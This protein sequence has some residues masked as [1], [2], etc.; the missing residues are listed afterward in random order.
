MS[1]A[2]GSKRVSKIAVLII[3]VVVAAGVAIW[4]SSSSNTGRVSAKVEIPANGVQVSVGRGTANVTVDN[5]G[6]APTTI[7]TIYVNGVGYSACSGGEESPE[8]G[9]FYP[10]TCSGA[11]C[12]S[13]N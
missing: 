4:F 13:A 6:S 3:V 11:I 9:V 10:T 12:N 2:I 5:I 1:K 8:P 7:N